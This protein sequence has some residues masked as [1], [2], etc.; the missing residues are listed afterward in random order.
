[1]R[2]ITMVRRQRWPLLVVAIVFLAL[3]GL[4]LAAV[5]LQPVTDNIFGSALA[6]PAPAG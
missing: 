1:M 5:L 3:G 4:V 6:L 2:E